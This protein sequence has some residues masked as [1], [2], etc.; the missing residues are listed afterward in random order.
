MPTCLIGLGSNQGDRGEMLSAALVA[1][2]AEP[3]SRVV[4]HSAWRETAPVGGPV[5]QPPYLN[6][7]ATLQ[8]SLVPPEL[9]RCL[10]DIESRLGRQR[11]QRW[12]PRSI[13]LDL[14]LYDEVVLDTPSLVLPHPRLA[15]RRFVLESAAEIAGAMVHPTIGWS[16]ARL[17]EHLNGSS[18]YVAITGPIAA[19]KTGLAERL[20]RAV[21]G[22][23]IVEQP[24]WTRLT[25]FY[26]DPAG[27][28]WE[29]EVEF[30]EER[31]RL[32]ATEAPVWQERLWVV[33]DFWF[34]QSA[35]FARAWL[36]A[37][38]YGV[39]CGRLDA[40][41][42][43]VVS[44]R[45]IV[46]LDAPVEQLLARIERRGRPCERPL[47]SD[48]LDRIRLAVLEETARPG[49]GPV[50]RLSSGDQDDVLA[51]VLAAVRGME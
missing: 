41:R 1:L 36:P 23:L 15:V 11:Q 50:L 48:Q 30:L 33:S 18:P 40:V 8:T 9:L 29:T 27:R 4:S 13:D 26:A 3:H 31:V 7:A 20:V 38:R 42:E 5:G 16:I 6:G 19:G 43:N 32:L 2:A 46:V 49:L 37:E 10:Q 35:A 14:L 25:A 17:L 28:G 34:G 47:T 51:E 22:R 21:S 44:P 45:L 39:F 24:D 12:G